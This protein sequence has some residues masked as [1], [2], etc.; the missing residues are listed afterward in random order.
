VALS[1]LRPGW[2]PMVVSCRAPL[3]VGVDEPGLDLAGLL[4]SRLVSVL[5]ADGVEVDGGDDLP[6]PLAVCGGGV[7]GWH[8]AA[9]CVVLDPVWDGV[10]GHRRRGRVMDV[11]WIGRAARRPWPVMQAARTAYRDRVTPH[12]VRGWGVLSWR[13][14]G[15][16]VRVGELLG[17]VVALGKCRGTGEGMVDGWRVERVCGVED[18]ARWVHVDE[19]GRLL[20]P[21]PVECAGAWCDSGAWEMGV[22]GL[23][24]PQVRHVVELATAVREVDGGEDPW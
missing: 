19:G 6:L 5:E 16:V 20:R 9:S 13:A 12:E 1:G 7:V 15:D 24:P 10:V 8:W 18:W 11:S 2:G 3:G 17:P 22:W 4:A 21:V 23:R 14:V